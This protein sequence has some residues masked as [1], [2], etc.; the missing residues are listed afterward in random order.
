MSMSEGK[1]DDTF[2]VIVDCLPPM[3]ISGLRMPRTCSERMPCSTGN[4]GS[5]R[6]WHTNKT[7]GGYMLCTG[8]EPCTS[9]RCVK[10]GFIPPAVYCRMSMD[11]AFAAIHANN[12]KKKNS[13]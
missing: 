12:E 5:T 13:T 10:K 3:P 9:E 8:E 2:D 11:D 4:C 6:C 7:C 1:I